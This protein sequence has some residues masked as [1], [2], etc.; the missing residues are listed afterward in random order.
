MKTSSS[1]PEDQ[2]KNSVEEAPARST[3]GSCTAEPAPEPLL[4]SCDYLV[5]GSGAMGLA[6][7]DSL[8]LLQPDASVMLVDK[9]PAPGGHWNDD[10]GYVLLHQP[11]LVYGVQSSQLEGSWLKLLLKGQVPLLHRANQAEI[12]RYYKEV[13]DKHVAAGNLQYF[14]SSSYDL[15]QTPEAVKYD[16]ED[17]NN[18]MI[19]SFRSLPVRTTG[20]GDGEGET[21]R[22]QHRRYRVKVKVMVVDAVQGEV[23][24]PATT[25][26]RFGVEDTSLIKVVTPNELHEMHHQKAQAS[27]DASSSGYAWKYVG[28]MVRRV[29]SWFFSSSEVPLDAAASTYVVLGCGKTGMDAI[30]YLI[31]ERKVK[32]ENIVWVSSRDVWVINR[33]RGG[34]S[35]YHQELLEQA[36]NHE[37]TMDSL[38]AKQLV[39][40]LDPDVRPTASVRFPTVS[41][42][43]IKT[44]RSVTNKIRQGRV[45]SISVVDNQYPRLVFEDGSDLVLRDAHVRDTVFVHC[46]APGPF[47]GRTV[48]SIY[49][50]V[51]V[52]GNSKSLKMTLFPILPP[53]IPLSGA[54]LARIETSRRNGT[55]DLEWG[56]ALLG[57]PNPSPPLDHP[58]APASSSS[59]PA[60]SSHTSA[61]AMWTKLIRPYIFASPDPKAHLDVHRNLAAFLALLDKDPAVGANWLSKGNRLSVYS[62]VEKLRAYENVHLMMD[63]AKT[64][65]YSDDEVR[66]LQLFADR[67]A[68]L[69]GR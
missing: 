34:P 49:S 50:E 21:E 5:V 40:R 69:Q 37:A 54:M 4:L 48:D 57:S 1:S 2:H 10:Y 8:L 22:A 31:S 7:V 6:F 63:H 23:Q 56:Q 41:G 30:V 58:T 68:P 51:A 53:P 46:T 26:P 66:T 43:E 28:W 52:A 62:W 55:C 39:Y 16:D 33:M 38:E 35:A 47:N 24:I 59:S 18:V 60:P 36:G 12:L 20:D 13:V 67:L 29:G 64:I 42:A 19:H 27:E 44:L 45:Q 15:D 11:S 17:D 61:A 3:E 9:H 32:P 25:P 14:P 65:G